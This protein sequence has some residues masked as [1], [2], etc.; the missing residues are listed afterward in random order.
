[1]VLMIVVVLDLKEFSLESKTCLHMANLGTSQAGVNT[2]AQ[3][4]TVPLT[5][6]DNQASLLQLLPSC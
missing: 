6:A 2:G 3:H 1:M 5:E 4:G